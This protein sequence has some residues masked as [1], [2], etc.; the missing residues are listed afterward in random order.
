MPRTTERQCR[1][2]RVVRLAVQMTMASVDH[3]TECWVH[4]PDLVMAYHHGQSPTLRVRCFAAREVAVYE[5]HQRK[6]RYL[7]V[8]HMS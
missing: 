6:K 5:S 3:L 1:W 7:K 2:T 4:D 8:Y